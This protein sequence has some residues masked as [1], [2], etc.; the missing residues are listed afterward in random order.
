MCGCKQWSTSAIQ[1]AVRVGY[2]R[3]IRISRENNIIQ[4]DLPDGS[5]I[6]PCMFMS[7]MLGVLNALI[8]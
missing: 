4:I 1:F 2:V 6:G 8:R 5:T 7:A 3:T